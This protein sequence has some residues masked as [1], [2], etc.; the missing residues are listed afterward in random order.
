MSTQSN[1]FNQEKIRELFH[2]QTST[3]FVLPS[4]KTDIVIGKPSENQTP[5]IDVSLLPNEDIIS[6]L[7]AVIYYQDDHYY[8][9]DL[10]SSNGTYLNKERLISQQKYKLQFQ[11]K[12]EL[13]KNNQVTFIFQNSHLSGDSQVNQS[14]LT[15]L[16]SA[17]QVNSQIKPVTTI[18]RFFGSVLMVASVI[19]LA[20]NIHIGFM[21]R[22]PSILLFLSGITVLFMNKKYSDLGWILIFIGI[23]AILFTGIFFATTNLLILLCSFILF[24]TGYQLFNTSKILNHSLSSFFNLFRSK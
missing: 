17:N 12:I 22:I 9:K 2:L 21:I 14:D 11:D 4:N 10:G 18:N 5:D 6:R 24:F 19:I 3:S 15:K 8:I 7:H 23:L 20:G 1:S 13:G 16:Q